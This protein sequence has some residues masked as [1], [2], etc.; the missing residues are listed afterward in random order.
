MTSPP[1]RRWA[2]VLSLCLGFFLNSLDGSIVAVVT[3]PVMRDLH[4]TTEAVLWVT[5]A[6]LLAYAAPLLLAGRLGDR[7]G[8]RRVYLVGTA[9]FVVA[10]VGCA[11][12]GTVGQLVA[13]RVV[14]GLGAALTAPQS[15]AIILRIVDTS[16]RG[17][18]MGVWSTVGAL[19]NLVAPPLGGVLA[20][21]VGWR[22]VF[23]VNVPL[24]LAVLL[25]VAR[26]VPVLPGRDVRLPVGGTVLSAAALGALT[27]GVQATLPTWA[28]A[29]L[30]VL[31]AGLGVV[32]WRSQARLG[33]GALVP[34]RLLSIRPFA[35]AV[36][37]V[38]VLALVVTAL[39]FPV[40]LWA[41]NAAG[42]SSSQAGLLLLPIGLV[43]A[44]A[45]A[46]IGR[47]V[48]R[49][50]PERLAARGLA[51][52]VAAT[53][54]L[55]VALLV[56][57]VPLVLVGA[58]VYGLAS[59]ASWS[60]TSVLSLRSLPHDLGG[61]GSA[62][63]NVARQLGMIIGAALTSVGVRL[64]LT[65]VARDHDELAAMVAGDVPFDAR[66]AYGVAMAALLA[67]L[68]L[69]NLAGAV[70]LARYRRTSPAAPSAAP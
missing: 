18:A 32:F 55:A 58:T 60:P 38:L 8:P 44:F 26:Q 23:W 39:P 20:A 34:A 61:A 19:A 11:L 42:M 36:A 56:R 59:S 28:S 63:Y 50:G 64:A 12:S 4:A 70:L 48:D 17:A 5:S 25:L 27:L 9:V 62:V 37:V 49:V 15:M 47:L 24:G 43:G 41:Q 45:G 2:P 16:W 53:A 1:G 10:S 30:L 66:S 6:Y 54:L 21:T 35:V 7:Y 3:P 22:W 52:A 65:S 67:V 13:A 33:E 40:M 46:P 29:A 68:T 69:V 51:L 57:S 14:Q 31:G